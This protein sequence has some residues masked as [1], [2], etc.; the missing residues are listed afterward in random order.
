MTI[1][2]S[3]HLPHVS[4]LGPALLTLWSL[5]TTVPQ[6]IGRVGW[7]RRLILS[8]PHISVEFSESDIDREAELPPS[9][10]DEA[11]QRVTRI[12]APRFTSFSDFSTI[13]TSHGVKSSISLHMA[14]T[15]QTA[16]KSTGGKAP[17]KQLATKVTFT[18]LVASPNGGRQ[19]FPPCALSYAAVITLSPQAARSDAPAT[20]GVKKPRRYRPGTVALLR[21]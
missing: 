3:R 7:I 15:K 2:Y 20:G 11:Q 5:L 14:R 17:R 21:L 19:T 8:M 1:K 18:P 6:F 9:G 10:I 13:M 12:I 16:R 4:S